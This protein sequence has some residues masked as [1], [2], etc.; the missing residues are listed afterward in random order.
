MPVSLNFQSWPSALGWALEHLKPFLRQDYIVTPMS[1]GPPKRRPNG[2]PITCFG[3]II[4]FNEGDWSELHQFTRGLETPLFKIARPDTKEV[5][6]VSL[7]P[8]ESGKMTPDTELQAIVV[9]APR[10]YRVSIVLAV[11]PNSAAL[12][13][14][15]SFS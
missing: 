3:G 5:C 9:G 11:N 15:R 10:K 14:D 1:A 4:D 6:L 12:L 8:N 2:T 13:T 7:A